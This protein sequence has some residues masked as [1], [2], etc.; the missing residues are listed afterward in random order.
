[1]ASVD[2]TNDEEVVVELQVSQMQQV[3][4]CNVFLL[5]LTDNLL[6]DSAALYLTWHAVRCRKLVLTIYLEGRKYDYDKVVV[7]SST[8]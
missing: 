1:M 2:L 4:E 3:S 5:L 8:Q 6:E 7:R